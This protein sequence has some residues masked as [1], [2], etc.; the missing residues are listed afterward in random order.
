M[1]KRNIISILL[2]GMMIL[3]AFLAGCSP[4]QPE[5]EDDVQS[6]DNYSYVPGMHEVYGV[7]FEVP[8]SEWIY[9]FNADQLGTGD[10][11]IDLEISDGEAE[12]GLEA[13]WKGART[14]ESGSKTIDGKECYWYGGSEDGDWSKVLLIPQS[15]DKK[16]I[17]I[18]S[19]FIQDK[20]SADAFFEELLEGIEFTDDKSNRISKDYIQVGGARIPAAGLNP[21][22]F[23]YGTMDLEATD[24][25]A[26]VQIDFDSEN[27]EKGAE[28]AFAEIGWED[29]ELL[30]DGPFENDGIKGKWYTCRDMFEEDSMSYMEH[31][32][33]IPNDETKT[34]VSIDYSFDGEVDDLSRYDDRIKELDGKISVPAAS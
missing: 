4:E 34:I 8:E 1:K 27:Y 32:I 15:D 29:L 18:R 6:E 25:M 17:E 11:F 13:V 24:G 19:D 5:D 21:A 3:S 16:Y 23:F 28:Q 10:E 22:Q 12:N 30:N 26:S 20:K 33:M 9:M 14:E 31:V 2:I 7:S